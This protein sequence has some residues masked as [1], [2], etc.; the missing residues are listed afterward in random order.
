MRR[1][2]RLPFRAALARLAKRYA[3]APP[4]LEV[5]RAERHEA[6]HETSGSQQKSQPAPHPSFLRHAPSGKR[7]RHPHRPATPRPRKCRNDDDLHPRRRRP[8]RKKP[9]RPARM[10]IAERRRAN[11]EGRTTNDEPQTRNP[12]PKTAKLQIPDAM[13]SSM[14]RCG[15]P[16]IAA[17]LFWVRWRR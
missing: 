1:E 7:T 4:P 9:P 5:R 11:F 14:S 10:T 15:M 17:R 6:R 16:N 13:S 2:V 3:P 8:R 12:K